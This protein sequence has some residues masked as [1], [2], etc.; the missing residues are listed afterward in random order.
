MGTCWDLRKG[1]RACKPNRM[2][3][4]TKCPQE[5]SLTPRIYSLTLGACGLAFLAVPRTERSLW[6]NG[7]FWNM[8][9]IYG[10]PIFRHSLRKHSHDL[11]HVWASRL[12]FGRAAG[13][14]FLSPTVCTMA[15]L[16]ARLMRT[17]SAALGLASEP[18][19]WGFGFGLRAWD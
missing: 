14:R 9:Q 5:T 15:N 17:P 19:V 2:L 4:H 3:G 18:S 12:S 16:I 6:P 1:K 13:A 8:P 7:S 10:T 11:R